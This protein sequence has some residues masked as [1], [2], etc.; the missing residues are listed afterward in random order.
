V[1]SG[2]RVGRVFG[3]NINIDWS[4]IFIFFLVTWNLASVFGG[5]HPDWGVVSR[6]GVALVASLLFFLSV[7]AHELAHSLMARGQGMSVRSITLFLFGGV[8][9]IQRHPPSP[10]A[11]FLIAIVGPITSIVLGLLF[12]LTSGVSV[13]TTGG[14]LENPSE[15]ISQLGPATTLLLWLGP[16]NLVLGVFNLIPGFPLDGG[17]I[18]RS[19][20]WAL[21]ENLKKATRW[22]SW[23]GQGI[24]WI[25]IVTGIA[26]MFG[27]SVPFFGGGFVDGLWLAFIGWFLNS[28]S[29]QSYQRV[30]VQDLLEGVEVKRV[31]RTN[32]P[33][34]T[35]D[36]SVSS[37]VHDHVM[38]T[39]DHAFPVVD[40]GSLIG[41]V[42]LEDIRNVPK[43][44]W[45]RKTVGEIMTPVAQVES[46]TEDDDASEALNMLQKRDVR[47][48]PVMRGQELV[49]LLRRRDIIRWLQLQADSS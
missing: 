16:I 41:I 48:L 20:L 15:M 40:G 21:T 12:I 33:T 25:M 36:Q 30:V 23:V 47:Q 26:M 49:G 39:D 46:V 17:R 13:F 37:L 32:A 8:S 29:A 31:M 34:V 6:W 9:N 42:A 35:S 2:F 14:P 27:A 10:T 11:E 19:V 24:A 43:E 5:A 44:N 7:L 22:A 4:W 3:I 38:G 18:L 1:G 28:A 45:E